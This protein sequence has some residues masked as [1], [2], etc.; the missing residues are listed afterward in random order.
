MDNMIDYLVWRGEFPVELTPWCPVDA[1]LFSTLCYLNFHGVDNARGWTLREAKRIDLLRDD[2][3]I[4]KAF[5]ARKKLFE[6]VADSVRFGDTRI[7]HFI[8][9]TDESRDMQFCAECVDLPDGTMGVVFRGTDNTIVGW[10]EDFNMAYQETVPAQEAAAYYLKKAAEFTD[11]PLR[12]MGHSKG[13]NLAVYSSCLAPEE[14]QGRILEIWSFDGPGLTNEMSASEGYSKIRERIHHYIP[15]TS[16][17]GLLMNYYEPYTVVHSTASGLAQHDPMSW[18]VKGPRFV[19]V[20][21]IDRTAVVIRDTLHDW[22]ANSTPEQRGAFMDN[23]FHMMES[24]GATRMSELSAEKWKSLL[25]MVGSQKS[26]PPEA[27]KIFGRLVAQAVTLGVGKVM[28]QVEEVSRSVIR[29]RTKPEENSAP[30][31]PGDSPVETGGE[32]PGD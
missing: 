31:D 26:A 25:T 23:L 32:A 11:R 29:N 8:A 27:R 9:M 20:E 6:T 12:L 2:T 7:H 19:E 18:E 3:A 1:L 21:S 28:D 10:R 13:G 5:P 30:A 4:S 16:I 17:I 15:Q 22:L 14:V 24:T